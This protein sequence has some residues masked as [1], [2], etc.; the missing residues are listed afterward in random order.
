MLEK[1][2]YHENF[3]TSTNTGKMNSYWISLLFTWS[4]WLPKSIKKFFFL[5]LNVYLVKHK[6]KKI[7]LI[8]LSNNIFRK[9]LGTMHVKFEILIAIKCVY[10]F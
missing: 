9:W 6:E 5:F 3:L 8:S 2:N 10:E 4:N 7:N 1:I